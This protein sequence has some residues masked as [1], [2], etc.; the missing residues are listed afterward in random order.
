MRKFGILLAAVA[1]GLVLAANPSE[2]GSVLGFSSIAGLRGVAGPG[3]TAS[4]A[5]VAG[6]R[7]AGDGGGGDFYDLGPTTGVSPPPT[8]VGYSG[9]GTLSQY[10]VT[11]MGTNATNGMVVGETVS[12]QGIPPGAQIASI[13]STT[14]ITMTL[15]ATGSGT[16]TVTVTGDNGGTLIIDSETPNQC[17]QKTNYRGDP[18]EWGAYGDGQSTHDDT[19]A[20]QYWLGAYGN[21]SSLA[22]STAPPTFGPWI[23][24]IPANYLISSPLTCPA[25]A[26]LQGFANNS[27]GESG[28][29]QPVVR[30]FANSANGFSG[31]TALLTAGSYCRISGIALDA[32]GLSGVDDIDVA[33]THVT[34]D[35]HTLLANA[36]TYGVLCPQA[37]AGEED[38]LQIKDAQVYMAG[39]DGIHLNPGCSNTRIVDTIVQSNG[40]NNAA[41]ASN[42][43]YIHNSTDV[44]IQ[45]GIVEQ[46][47]GAGI[48]MTGANLTSINGVVFDENGTGHLGTNAGQPNLQIDSS[49]NVTVCGNRIQG[50][51]GDAPAAAQVLFSGASDN[52]TFCGNTYVTRSYGN[53]ANVTPGYVYDVSSTSPPVLTNTHLYETP[54]LP[55]VSTFSTA[56]QPLLQPLQVSPQFNPSQLSGLILS[57]DTGS[58]NTVIDVAPGSAADS[59]SST[60]INLPSGCKINFLANGAGGL[61]AGAVANSTTYY[62]FA[63]AA[64]IANPDGNS[65]PTPSCMA[66]TSLTPSF[67]ATSFQGSGYQEL[68]QGGTVSGSSTV[69]NAIPQSGSVNALAAAQIGDAIQSNSANAIPAGTTIASFSAN[70]VPNTQLTGAFSQNSTSVT[71]SCGSSCVTDG[72]VGGMAIQDS[73]GGCIPAGTYIADTSQLPTITISQRTNNV[74]G[75]NVSMNTLSISG[76]RQINLSGAAGATK[77]SAQFTI[78]TGYYRLIGALYTDSGSNL[79]QFTQD[80]DTFYLKQSVQDI[81]APGTGVGPNCRTYISTTALSCLLSVP[82][83]IG[84]GCSGNSAI[85]VEAFGRV[86]AGSNELLLSS[87]DQNDQA[88]SVFTAAPG[89][90]TIDTATTMP[91]TNP[92]TSHPFRLYTNTNGQ[93]RVRASGNYTSAYEVTDGWVLRRAQC[94]PLTSNGSIV[95]M[96]C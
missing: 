54:A 64:A 85:K 12:G 48:Y 82:C 19:K 39:S 57:N 87:I 28:N 35:G 74:M 17:W 94:A 41:G 70:T 9:N 15:P 5:T 89:Y 25:Y 8:C 1:A 43:I 76:A 62:I 24:S 61:D 73:Q 6:Y 66:S 34:I 4:N 84:T 69:Y 16:V 42:G 86:V 80:A 2:S 68:G 75:C 96:G 10:K 46:T 44:S 3:P 56:A 22:P 53:D 67:M 81:A 38:G 13:T 71:L 60:L 65:A 30:I 79:V 92:T 77:P 63:I 59:T 55:S 88:P 33:G 14:S 91:P 72:V 11:G 78:S 50:A 83:G 26:V 90:S 32:T 51:G 45:G 31:G 27:T 47:L 23:A 37:G 58:P 40:Q 29:Y 18:H 52:V 36:G 21:E 49:T 93:V 20:L 95:G 7:V